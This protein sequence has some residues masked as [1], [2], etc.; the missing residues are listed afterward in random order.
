LLSPLP[1]VF[2][3]FPLLASDRQ[4][5]VS[6]PWEEAIGPRKKASKRKTRVS[7]AEALRAKKVA[8]QRKTS[9]RPPTL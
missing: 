6:C 5:T 3:Q 9:P 2:A 8:G 7:A 4:K 1:S